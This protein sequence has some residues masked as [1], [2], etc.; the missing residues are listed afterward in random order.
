LIWSRW[1]ARKAAKAMQDYFDQADAW[2]RGAFVAK[3]E[4]VLAKTQRTLELQYIATGEALG[5][6]LGRS[7]GSVFRE[8]QALASSPPS[9]DPARDLQDMGVE[10]DRV[11]VIREEFRSLAR[12]IVGAALREGLGTMTRADL[13]P[14]LD[15][16]TR[17]IVDDLSDLP[18]PEARV[19]EELLYSAA[20]RLDPVPLAHL[21]EAFLANGVRRSLLLPSSYSQ[22][23][24]RRLHMA[25][26]P[27]GVETQLAQTRLRGPAAFLL[28][29]S[30]D[31]DT[32]IGSLEVTQPGAQS[33]T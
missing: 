30:L 4:W 12:Q 18:T 23:L 26:A 2:L 6:A 17:Q 27:T 28:T 31:R 32:F 33:R 29:P 7:F 25:A 5:R 3:L 19:S 21:G 22:D 8:W 14:I 16:L 24:M 1:R 15:R 13:G 11:E 10:S 9:G 20:Q